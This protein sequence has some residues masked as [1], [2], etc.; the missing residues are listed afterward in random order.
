[1]YPACQPTSRRS[2]RAQGT[3]APGASIRTNTKRVSIHSLG[4][5]EEMMMARA[6]RSRWTREGGREG[7][8]ITKDCARTALADMAGPP[9]ATPPRHLSCR[10]RG[11]ACRAV[12]WR[13]LPRAHSLHMWSVQVA[14]FVLHARCVLFGGKISLGPWVQAKPERLPPVSKMCCLAFAHTDMTWSVV[15]V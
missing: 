9:E 15:P 3:P 11:C 7:R 10:V 13:L 8:Q 1:M 12:T 2:C 4:M 14:A 5:D 6:A